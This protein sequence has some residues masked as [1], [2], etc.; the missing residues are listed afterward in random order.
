MQTVTSKIAK[1]RL[2]EVFRMA[3]AEPVEITHH[4]KPTVYVVSKAD[5]ERL[6]SPF[7][8]HGNLDRIKF[9]I[10]TEVV[11][12][13]P[14]D[15]IRHK[16]LANLDRWAAKGVTGQVYDE[17]RAILESGDDHALLRAMLSSD[18][19]GNRL[20][21]SPPY[22]GML[23]QELVMQMK[24]TPH[25]DAHDYPQLLQLTW[26]RATKEMSEDEAFA[27]YEARFRWIDLEMMD[28]NERQFF[29]RLVQVYGKGVINA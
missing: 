20:R 11:A 6:R 15:Q 24:A 16:S 13:F 9:R 4:G 2:G 21:Q 1:N 28:A 8:D 18:E 29:D 22:V 17:W 14:L 7:S 12:R 27:L 3:M 26:D 25:V 23:D 5:F 10:A 19:D